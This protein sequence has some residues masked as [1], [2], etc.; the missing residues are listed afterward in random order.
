MSAHTERGRG[1]VGPSS[2]RPRF[3]ASGLPDTAAVP[4]APDARP[5][6]L[7]AGTNRAGRTFLRRGC[8]SGADDPPV[9]PMV[10]NCPSMRPLRPEVCPGGAGLRSLRGQPVPSF[11]SHLRAGA[12]RHDDTAADVN[13]RS[14]CHDTLDSGVIVWVTRKHRLHRAAA[15]AGTGTTTRW[16]RSAGD[17]G[18]ATAGQPGGCQPLVQQPEGPAVRWRREPNGG[19]T[20]DQGKDSEEDGD[21]AT[22]RG[23]DHDN[24]LVKTVVTGWSHRS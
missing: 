20:G 18:G 8:P 23:A 9:R 13:M 11:D 17:D 24:S 1:G 22:S 7:I 19:T 6:A 12:V 3:C 15:P 4:G 5:R 14:V 2:P 16:G 21:A 10:G